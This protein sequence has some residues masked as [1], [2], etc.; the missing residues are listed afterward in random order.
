LSGQA[1][2]A[3]W[4]SEIMLKVLG[5]VTSINVRKVLWAADELGL[6]YEQEDWGLP[7]RDPKVPEFLALNPNGQVPV[8]L[9]DGFALWESNAILVYLADKAGDGRL[10]PQNAQ[11]RG[12][13]LQWLGWQASELNPTWGYA[14][15]AL[16][17][18]T[19]GF[20]D[21]SRIAESL[22]RWGEAMAILEGA[23]ADG[24]PFAAGQLFTV[25]DIALALSVH[26]WVKT[27]AEKPGLP[28]VE[29]YH[30]RMMARPAGAKW[31]ADP[32]F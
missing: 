16:L 29:A 32:L 24:R 23:L 11:K 18:H 17:R 30:Q 12:L 20:E 7:L 25:A 14:V 21:S 27:P 2:I 3:D 9:D 28:G 26:R 13:A 15:Q 4:R 5:R 1:E 22:R 31:M 10:L 6:A 8:L 19:P